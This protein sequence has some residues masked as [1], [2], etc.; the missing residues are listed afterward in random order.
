MGIPPFLP[1]PISGIGWHIKGSLLIHNHAIH[2]D[3][4]SRHFILILQIYWSVMSSELIKRCSFSAYSGALA[5]IIW[6]G[7]YEGGYFNSRRSVA[8]LYIVY[9]QCIWNNRGPH[10]GSMHARY[11]Y[12]HSPQELGPSPMFWRL[13]TASEQGFNEFKLCSGSYG[14]AANCY[15][16]K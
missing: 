13:Q 7:I 11:D 8:V 5:Y 14:L 6:M 15:C 9:I 12:D 2:L 1:Q 10:D 3:Q 4:M 16:I